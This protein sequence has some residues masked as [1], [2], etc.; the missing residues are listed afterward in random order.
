[1]RG[2]YPLAHPSVKQNTMPTLSPLPL[3]IPLASVELT[4]LLPAAN[5]SPFTWRSIYAKLS[6]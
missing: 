1:M 4:L 6:P 5:P 2:A 3:S